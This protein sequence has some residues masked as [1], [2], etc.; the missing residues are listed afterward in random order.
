MSTLSSLLEKCLGSHYL[1]IRENFGI[2]I[3]LELAVCLPSVEFTNLGQD[4]QL[5]FNINCSL[6]F[7]SAFSSGS[8]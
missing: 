1:K 4:V 7:Y 3:T 2:R 6:Q 5:A 8:F